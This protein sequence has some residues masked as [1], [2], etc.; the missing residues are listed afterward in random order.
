MMSGVLM[1]SS[2]IVPLATGLDYHLL[3]WGDP[4]RPTVVLVHGFLDLAWGWQDV[5]EAGLADHFHVVAPD[6]RGHGDSGWVGAGGYYHFADYVADLTELLRVLG[7]ERVSLVGHSMGGN[8]SSMFAGTFPARVEK[9]ALLEGL[10][11]PEMMDLGPDRL[12][13]WLASWERVR[14][15][16]PRTYA[17]L[18]EAA[19]RLLQNDPL[20]DG[21]LALRLARHGTK[22]TADGRLRYKHD[23]LHTTLAYYGFR[24]EAMQRFWR[25]IECPVL[26]IDGRLSN[27]R[28]ADADEARRVECLK[29]VTRT[30]IDGAGHMMQRHQPRAV[31]E[32]LINFL[33]R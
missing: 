9:L 6:L 15:K 2:R 12:R 4:L 21:E 28:L 30:S 5:A 26:L 32:A 8:V 27:F 23:P 19:A 25:A 10:G 16:P 33:A 1:P 13:S 11:P 14:D 24:L 20:L 18:D 7:K 22:P 3:E 29:D 17:N 31:A